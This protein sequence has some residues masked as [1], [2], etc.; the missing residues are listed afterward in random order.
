[1][2]C[3]ELLTL[4]LLLVYNGREGF[5]LGLDGIRLMIL[6]EGYDEMIDKDVNTDFKVLVKGCFR[7]SGPEKRRH[8]RHPLRIG[9]GVHVLDE[10]VA[11]TPVPMT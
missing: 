7:T 11:E 1:M 3:Y 2:L 8:I 5:G 9:D 10:V 6:V 4:S